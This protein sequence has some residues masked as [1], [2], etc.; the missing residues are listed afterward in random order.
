M[1]DADSLCDRMLH[2]GGKE[3]RGRAYGGS[4]GLGS[5]ARAGG[6]M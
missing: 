3:A 5:M 4:K 2:R 6:G 1:R